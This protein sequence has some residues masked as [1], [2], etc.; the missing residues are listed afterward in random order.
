MWRTVLETEE[1]ECE[2]LDVM[3]LS[4]STISSLPGSWVLGL[5]FCALAT[6]WSAECMYGHIQFF[7]VPQWPQCP[8]LGDWWPPFHDPPDTDTTCSRLH[9][10]NGIPS[11]YVHPHNTLGMSAPQRVV[12][13]LSN[14]CG[15]TGIWAT[16]Y[17]ALPFCELNLTSTNVVWTP[18][19]GRAPIPT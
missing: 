7:T 19:L 1:F 18:A 2:V 12:S 5:V 16:Q 6:D 17:D 8:S 14:N 11:P 4:H 10:H 3:S 13:C 9:A 15:S